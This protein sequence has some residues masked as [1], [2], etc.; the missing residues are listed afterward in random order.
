LAQFLLQ[1]S[2]LR[3]FWRAY[4]PRIDLRD[5]GVR[6]ILALA[7]TVAAGLVVTIIANLIDVNLFLRLPEG[8]LT[9][10]EYATRIIQFPLGIVGL[11]VSFAVLPTLS[12]LNPGAGGTLAEYRAALAFAIKLVLVLML[13]A[14]AVGVAL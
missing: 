14:L 5:P 4:R 7:G 12:R 8:N 10:R 6:R 1:A 2:G 11:A 9:S 3:E 13:P